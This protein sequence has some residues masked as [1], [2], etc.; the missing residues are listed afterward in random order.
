MGDQEDRQQEFEYYRSLVQNVGDPMYVLD[1]DGDIELVNNAMLEYLELDE[2]EVVG[3][4]TSE[5]MVDGDFEGGTELIE[6]LVNDPDRTSGTFEMTAVTPA[7]DEISSETNIGILVD[8]GGD[9]A[10]NVGVVRD[11]TDR[12][13]REEE[14][15]RKNWRLEEFASVVSHDLRNPLNVA[16]LRV[17]LVKEDCESDHLDPQEHALDRMTVL[18]EDLLTLAR[19]GET[20]SGLEA[21]SLEPVVEASWRSV[22]TVDATLITETDSTILTD[23]N[24]LKQLFENLFRNAI[25]HAGEDVTVTVGRLAVGIYVADDGPGIPEEDREE[26]FVAGLS[27][28]EAGTGFGLTIVKQIVEAHDG[29]FRY[30]GG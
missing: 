12:K 17:E 11:I 28:A 2:E 19:Q 10:G 4:H 14:L 1:R 29:T 23:L 25:E 26:L 15:E 24:R 13:A 27:P 6:S 9:F 7:G 18:V 22:E 20:V 16:L 30:C 8:D 5:F 3:T 21:V